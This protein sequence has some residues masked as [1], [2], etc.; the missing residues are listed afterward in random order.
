MSTA[1]TT[2]AGR[3]F[4]A[5]A[6]KAQ[7]LYLAWGSG[8]PEWDE[9]DDSD[10][11]S[12]VE[13]TALANELGR[14]VPAAVGFVVPDENGSV[15]IPIGQDGSGTVQYARYR[16]VEE[17][18]AW[19]YI[20]CNFDNADA[21]NAVIREAAIFGG[22]TVDPELPP[23]QQYFTPGEIVHPGFMLAM[24]IVRP[25]F[26]RSPSVRESYEFVLPV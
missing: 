16:Q 15:I 9:M 10:L 17:P 23:G 3:A 11:P 1:T 24:E 2:L 7:P 25:R 12:M 22:T 4:M 20:R 26:E 18:S 5:A 19:L 8:D 14:R 6:V 21:S 13:M